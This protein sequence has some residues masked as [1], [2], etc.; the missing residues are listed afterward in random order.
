MQFEWNEQKRLTN[1]RKH[2]IDFRDAWQLFD[3]PM[4]VA[5]DERADDGEDRCHSERS[6]ESLQLA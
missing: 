3:A 2:G 1:I 4:L 5:L 6:E